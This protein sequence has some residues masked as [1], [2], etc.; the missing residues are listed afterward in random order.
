MKKIYEDPMLEFILFKSS[1]LT[2][3]EK[4]EEITS[5]GSGKGYQPY[6]PED[7]DLS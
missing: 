1:L 6:I 2:G 7:G 5:G 3:D 4:S